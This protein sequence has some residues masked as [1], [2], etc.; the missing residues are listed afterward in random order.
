MQLQRVGHDW[1]G[2]TLSLFHYRSNTYKNVHLHLP[3]KIFWLTW[4]HKRNRSN[5]RKKKNNWQM[6]ERVTYGKNRERET[7]IQEVGKLAQTWWYV[8]SAT[9]YSQGESVIWMYRKEFPN[10]LMLKLSV[11]WTRFPSYCCCPPPPPTQNRD[12]WE[13]Q[14][15]GYVMVFRISHERARFACGIDSLCTFVSFCSLP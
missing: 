10:F 5:I 7:L 4:K 1:V 6:P 13:Y 15:H 12:L 9:L 8:V 11:D 14:G 2:L 3:P